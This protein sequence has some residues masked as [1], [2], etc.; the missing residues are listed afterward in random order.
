MLLPAEYNESK[1]TLLYDALRILLEAIAIEKGFKIYNHECYTAFIREV[2]K[3]SRLADEFDKFRRI[4]NAIN[5][6]AKQI[7]NEEAETIVPGMQEFIK[8]LNSLYSP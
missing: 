1:I 2:L 6:Y 5:Y 3:E 4:R 8:R 7:S